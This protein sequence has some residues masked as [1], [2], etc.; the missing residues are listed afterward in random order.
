LRA[1]TTARRPTK[2]QHEAT[3]IHASKTKHMKISIGVHYEKHKP[4]EIQYK[5]LNEENTN[6]EDNTWPYNG[7]KEMNQQNRHRQKARTVGMVAEIQ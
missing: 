1:E 2:E 6:P 7:Q 5:I 3:K 4:K